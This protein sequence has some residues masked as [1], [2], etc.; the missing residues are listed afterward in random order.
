[1][2]EVRP[3]LAQVYEVRGC[4]IWRNCAWMKNSVRFLPFPI[5]LRKAILHSVQVGDDLYDNSG[6][7]NFVPKI[8]S[9]DEIRNF[10]LSRVFL[11][12]GSRLKYVDV[13][14]FCEETVQDYD[15]TFYIMLP[16]YYLRPK[17]TWAQERAKRYIM[18]VAPKNPKVHF[19]TF[20]RKGKTRVW[21]RNLMKEVDMLDKVGR[22]PAEI[23]S[24]I[25]RCFNH[26]V[27]A[28]YVR[29]KLWIHK[30]L[31][32][33]VPQFYG[34]SLW[35]HKLKNVKL[36]LENFVKKFY[37]KVRAAVKWCGSFKLALYN[38]KKVFGG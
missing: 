4:V 18:Y 11:F 3:D 16:E 28:Y 27:T 14:R 15:G 30:T 1:M 6:A 7:I 37:A 31:K 23:A 26:R 22:S 29:L 34:D 33:Y 10:P 32:K 24:Y 5:Q 38:V 20:W 12:H 21:D 13:K 36:R 19:I 35:W 9:F 8:R 25:F 2:M 17:C